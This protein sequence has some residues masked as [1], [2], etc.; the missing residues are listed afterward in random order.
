METTATN[1]TLEILDDVNHFYLMVA[2]ELDACH[3]E[4]FDVLYDIINQTYSEHEIKIKLLEF[5]MKYGDELERCND[6]AYDQ[7]KSIL[8]IQLEN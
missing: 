5:E 2:D 7:L 4:A 3:P 8:D 1:I 6:E